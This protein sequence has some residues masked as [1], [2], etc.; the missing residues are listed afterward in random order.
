M[1]TDLP[2][3]SAP[4]ED[5]P[6]PAAEA[7]HPMRRVT[8]AVAFDPDGWTASRREQVT[9][10]FDGL[11]GDWSASRD[12]PGRAAPIHDALDRGL[13]A[14]PVAERRVALDIGGGDGINTRHLSPPFATLVTVDLSQEMLRR[15]ADRSA[16]RVR[17][18]SSQLPVADRSI[19]A[20]V[21]ANAFLFPTEVDRTLAERGVVI[22]VNSRG[23]GTPIHLLASEVDEALPGDWSGVASSAGWGTWS[24]H[25]RST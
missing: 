17:A 5:D 11:A 19:D 8:R 1:I 12:L 23:A 3:I 18:D 14:A 15:A 16:R 20:L 7:D 9:D 13:A 2:S 22:W 10:L 25:W 21:L 6:P 24:V 4:A